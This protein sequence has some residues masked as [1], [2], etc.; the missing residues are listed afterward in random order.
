MEQEQ[1]QT[2]CA[3]T[4]F[5]LQGLT[6]DCLQTT[7]DLLFFHFLD[8]AQS[9]VSVRAVISTAQHNVQQKQKRAH[10]AGRAW[11]GRGHG[12]CTGVQALLF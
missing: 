11:A 9:Q 2:G 12:H 1:H 4:P 7:Y 6:F 8:S 5:H 10:A 3:C